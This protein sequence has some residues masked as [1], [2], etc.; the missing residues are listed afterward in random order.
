MT[1]VTKIMNQ[2]NAEVFPM[3]FC[4][5]SGRRNLLELV[6]DVGKTGEGNSCFSYQAASKLLGCVAQEVLESHGVSRFNPELNMFNFRQW[7]RNGY[8]EC[9]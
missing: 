7:V 6:E 2:V 9:R 4:T 5:T 3:K 8:N 1:K